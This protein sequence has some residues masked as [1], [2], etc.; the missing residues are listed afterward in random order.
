VQRLVS[1]SRADYPQTTGSRSSAEEAD[2]FLHMGV[3]EENAEGLV[4]R[5]ARML[6]TLAPMADELIIYS[7]PGAAGDERHAAVFAVPIEDPGCGDLREPFDD[8]TAIGSTTL[9]R[10]ISRRLTR[11]MVFDDVLVPWDRVFLHGSVEIGNKL[12]VETNLRQHTAHQTRGAWTGEHAVHH[13]RGDEARSGGEDR[14]LPARPAQARELVAATETCRALIRAAEIGP[15]DLRARATRWL[16]VPAF[17][18]P[19]GCICRRP[20][21]RQ[22]KFCRPSAPGGLLMMPSAEDF[23]SERSAAT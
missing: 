6:A 15:R 5:G 3:V 2:A 21:R 23:G 20:T 11:W 22:P 14:R 17:A 8:G 4:V 10:R 16:R 1:H 18:E 19:C 7:L 9:F 12:Y 13:R